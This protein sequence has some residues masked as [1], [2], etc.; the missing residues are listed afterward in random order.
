MSRYK[1]LKAK[2]KEQEQ[3]LKE[4]NDLITELTSEESKAKVKELEREVE[5]NEELLV[6][7]KTKIDTLEKDILGGGEENTKPMSK[8]EIAKLKQELKER[9][10]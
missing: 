4:Q 1:T 10:K 8:D 6:K 5:E 7:A 3:Q 9:L 2:L